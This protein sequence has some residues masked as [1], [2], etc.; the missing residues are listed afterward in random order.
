MYTNCSCIDRPAG[1]SWKFDAIDG[2]CS[3]DCIYLAIFMPFFG[4][5][6]LL[7]FVTSMP[8]LQATLRF[9][10][11]LLLQIRRVSD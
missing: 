8:A 4:F 2:K 3:S 9:V 11:T 7:T 6:M 5:I 10:P 1:Q